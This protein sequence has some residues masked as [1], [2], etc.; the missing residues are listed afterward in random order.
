MRFLFRLF[1]LFVLVIALVWVFRE[2]LRQRLG[3]VAGTS[4]GQS[5]SERGQLSDLDLS[6]ERIAQEL[7][8]TG[9]VVRRKVAASL[10]AP[11]SPTT[12]L[13]RPDAADEAPPAVESLFRRPAVEVLVVRLRVVSG[14]VDD[15]VPM[16]RRRVERI[17]LQRNI[18][19]VDDVVIR[20]RRDDNREARSDRRPNAI[21]KG[22]TCPLL[23]AKE[24]VELVDFRSDLFLGP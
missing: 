9:R 24:L 23:H 18:A 3:L 11:R 19:G 12:V 10:A 7:R 21:E 2:P 14:M 16:I 20:P 17:E 1:L 8:A 5:G 13:S 22:L 15:A 4:A 6:V